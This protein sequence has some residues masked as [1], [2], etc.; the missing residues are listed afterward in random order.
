MEDAL[1]EYDLHAE[2]SE[3]EDR[4]AIDFE[5][6]DDGDTL[7]ATVWGSEPWNDVQIDCDHPAVEYSDDESVGECPICGATCF[8]HW[9]GYTD[10]DGGVYKD[11]VVDQWDK[12]E[13]I[14]GIVGEYLKGLQRKW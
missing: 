14:S 12:P 11:R 13:K 2:W 4:E 6:R 8:W 3:A 9:D 5:I 7:W 1:N 10:G